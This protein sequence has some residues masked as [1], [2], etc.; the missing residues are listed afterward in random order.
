MFL[1]MYGYSNDKGN[2]MKRKISSLLAMLIMLCGLSACTAEEEPAVSEVFALNTYVTQKVYGKEKQPAIEEVNEFLKNIEKKLSLYI[3]GSD[4][5]RINQ[6]AG[7]TPVKVEDYT[8]DLIQIGKRY[9]ELSEGRFDITIAPL[10]ILW[11]ITSEHPKVPTEAEIKAAQ[12][13]IDYPKIILNEADGTVMLE[14]KGMALDLGGIA[15]GYIS[16]AIKAIYDKHSITSALVSIGGNIDAYGR[17][18]NGEM[19]KLG[20][21]D[22]KDQTGLD[23]I[24][25]LQVEDKVVAT[26]GAY[27]RFFVDKETGETYHHILDPKTGYPAETDLQS[28]T[29]ISND[30]GLSDYLSTTLF[31]AGKEYLEDYIHDN[32]FDVI[33]VDKDNQIY[34]SDGIKDAFE[35]TSEDYTLV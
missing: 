16:N 34:L 7:V 13:L 32:R 10:T 4:I 22:P 24:G 17:K 12:K 14:E 6:N 9:S 5:D 8:F 23:Y 35:L 1:I 31:M 19:Y 11:G 26:S 21:R 15:K 2:Q 20:I 30:G 3:T 27:E 28:V 18:P 33:V 29:V 25:K